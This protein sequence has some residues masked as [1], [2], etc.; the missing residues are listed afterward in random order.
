MM[1]E[2]S[3]YLTMA[4]KANTEDRSDPIDRFI[5]GV[6]PLSRY[7]PSRSVSDDRVFPTRRK[8]ASEWTVKK[9]AFTRSAPRYISHRLTSIAC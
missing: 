2:K 5:R 3:R 7:F 4:T 1:Q 6:V 8:F 9:D